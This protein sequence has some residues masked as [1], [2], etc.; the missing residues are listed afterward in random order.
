MAARKTSVQKLEGTILVLV[1]ACVASFVVAYNNTALMTALPAVKSDFDMDAVTLQWVMNSYLLAAASLVVVMGRFSDIFGKMR[2]FLF[3]VIV[4]AISSFVLT[5]SENTLMMLAFRFLQGI[6]ASSVFSNSAALINVTT[7]EK[8]RPVAI[9]IW[10]AVITFGLGV[11][12]LMGGFFTEVF[13]WRLI[14]ATDVILLLISLFLAWRL[15][16]LGIVKPEAEKRE[17]VDYFGAVVLTLTLASLV[18]AV[19]HGKTS[20]WTSPTILAAFA[21]GFAGAVVFYIAEHRIKSPLVHFGLFECRPYVGAT[22]AMFVVGYT[23]FGCFFFFNLFLQ[24]PASLHLSAIYAGLAV[25]P[26]SIPMLLISVLLPKRLERHHFRWAIATGMLALAVGLGLM[27]LTGNQTTYA[28]IWWKFAIIGCGFGLTFP[29]VPTVG[30]RDL[31]DHHAGQGSG[32]I[33]TCLFIGAISGVVGGG[34]ITAD[35]AHEMMA[36]AISALP[37]KPTAP[38]ELIHQLAHGSAGDVKTA[39]AKFSSSDA[40]Q[41]KS[42]LADLED[43]TFDAVMLS[44]AVVSAI[45]MIASITLMRD[46]PMGSIA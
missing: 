23:L 32:V 18:Y 19:S 15:G 26:I 17:S 12:P 25:L 10:A 31:A 2:L 37:D 22:I 4:F 41:L 1:T 11:G 45:G 16:K 6:G 14:F 13:S 44:M 8:E 29:L 40:A 34:L 28:G 5:F 38:V 3:G 7:P 24:S 33:N 30:L 35:V 9:G 46:R 43:D 42:T 27:S 39:L 36:N 21:V 20:G